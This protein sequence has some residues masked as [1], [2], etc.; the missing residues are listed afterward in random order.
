ML[1]NETQLTPGST[2]KI[3]GDEVRVVDQVPSSRGFLTVCQGDGP[4]LSLYHSG[5]LLDQEAEVEFVSAPPVPGADQNQTSADAAK[6]NRI[7]ELEAKLASAEAARGS[8]ES[9]DPTGSTDPDGT[10]VPES[11]VPTPNDQVVQEA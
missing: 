3:G 10:P 6:D 5:D 11:N 8:N 7:A 4:L 1:T 9:T 2:I